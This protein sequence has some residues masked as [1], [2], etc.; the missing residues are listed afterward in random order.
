M[1]WNTLLHSCLI[2]ITFLFRYELK[3]Y[4]TKY[5]DY[6]KAFGIPVIILSFI[7]GTPETI[8][9]T[10]PQEGDSIYTLKTITGNNLSLYIMKIIF[11]PVTHPF[12]GLSRI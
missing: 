12:K 5:E 3:G 6:M 8:V 7:I 2:Q 4:D 1:K 9:F 10:E 11:T